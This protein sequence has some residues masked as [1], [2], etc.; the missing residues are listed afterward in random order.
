MKIRKV[1]L[2]VLLTAVI[3]SM[4]L[5]TACTI[6]VG[7]GPDVTKDYDFKD[8]SK[9]NISHGFSVQIT[10]SSTYKV[11]VTVPENVIEHLD[12]KQ[13]GDTVS[14]GLEINTYSNV[15][16]RA[17]VTMPDLRGCSLSGGSRG[18]VSGFQ[19][20]SALELH[21][22]GGSHFDLNITAGQTR[23]DVSGGGRVEGQLNFTDVTANLSGGS[24]WE[25]T[26]TGNNL[27]RL[28]ASGGSQV[29]LPTVSLQ[30]ASIYLSG[31]S[32]ADLM[33]NG[34]LSLDL[35]GGSKLTYS[36]NPQIETV[37]VSGGSNIS[38]R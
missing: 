9:L 22:S 8:F 15:H 13:I 19:S 25:T 16:P 37:N 24:R 17:V 21:S 4:A 7:A 14:I 36:G 6:V 1:G 35:S 33:V 29:I 23:V 20:G 28:V 26:G 32:R 10:A 12:V 30:N 31:G 38:K 27:T 2:V 34:K 18:T 5:G 11:S 3:M